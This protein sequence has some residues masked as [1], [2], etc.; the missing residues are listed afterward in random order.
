MIIDASGWATDIFSVASIPSI[1]GMFISI[2]KT[3]GLAFSIRSMASLPL[4]AM[5][6]TSISSSKDKSFEMLAQ[7]SGTSSTIITLMVIW[8]HPFG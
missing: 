8:Y 7:V 6:T 1:T 3:S 5:P 2:S 4:F